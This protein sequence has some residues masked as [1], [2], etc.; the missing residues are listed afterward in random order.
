MKFLDGLSDDLKKNLL[1]GLRILW[2][3]ASTS[4]EGNTLTLGETAFVLSEGLTIKGKPLKDHRDVEGHARAVDLSLALVKKDVLTTEDLFDL[5]IENEQRYDYITAL[6]EYHL[7]NGVTTAKRELVFDN[8]SLEKFQAVCEQS[9]AKS[10]ALIE[11]AKAL[12]NA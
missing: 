5:H 8:A 12:Q 10:R 1:E 3:Q 9:W 11:Q 6:S 4:I 7:A 2:T